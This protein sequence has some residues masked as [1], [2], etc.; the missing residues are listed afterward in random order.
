MILAG[1]DGHSLARG[2]VIA[3]PRSGSGKTMLTLG[4]MRA[5]RNAG[6]AVAGA[7]C[8][9]DYIDPAFHAAAT[10]KQ[11]FNLDSWAMTPAQLGELGV[12]AG[13]ACE[14]ILCEGLMGLFDGVPGEPGRTGSSADVAA[15]LG[16]P[17]LLVLDIS[18]QS[19]TAAAIVQGCASFDPRIKI[20]GVVLNR[21]AS[22]RHR[23]L[24]S[25]SIE[26]LGIPVLGALPRDE[27]ISL[28]ER[29]LGLV[30]AG[31]TA[32]LDAALDRIADFINA[33]VDAGAILASAR[34][35]MIFTGVAPRALPPP[36][37]R[38]AIARDAAFS[39]LYPHILAG[40]RK[41]GADIVF[42]SPLANE[43][44][45]ED[46]DLLW[47]PGGYPELHAGRLAAAER[48]L[49]GLRRF[50][51]TKPAHGECG[52]YM[53]LGQSL[54]D[55]AGHAHRMAGLLGAS[56]SFAKRK[57]HL[58][59]RQVRLAEAHPLGAKGALLR[60][61]EF[62]Y[63]TIAAASEED[64]P[65]AFV[66][67]AHGGPEQAEGSRRGKVTGSFFHVIAAEPPKAG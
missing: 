6:L 35:S 37:Q 11:S 25:A 41:A 42:F 14:L 18:G 62:H 54:I 40:W 9:P 12:A 65:F 30:Q 48:F 16:W 52:G 63:A 29:H 31:E 10:G 21:V 36:A 61:H 22:P 38:V 51:E 59:Y 1:H 27:K 45:P 50:A 60:G 33:H 24:V 49:K 3:A 28:P 67:D 20:A 32:G 43:P 26:A 17:V 23:S 46:C 5:F 15:A 44:P 66:H 19:Q 47:L 13:D 34:A 4:L 64:Q 56:F 2:L 39:F 55:Q 8:G 7:K 53:I 57:L 58:G